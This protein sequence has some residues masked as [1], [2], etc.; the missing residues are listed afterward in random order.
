MSTRLL[1]AGL[2]LASLFLHACGESKKKMPAQTA[3]STATVN[4]AFERNPPI[5]TSIKVKALKETVN[6]NNVLLTATFPRAVIRDNVHSIV[7]NDETLTLRDDGSEGDEKADDGIFSVAINEDLS[8]L[9]EDLIA[10]QNANVDKLN[11][12]EHLFRWSGRSATVIDNQVRESNVRNL[13]FDKGAD[14]NPDLFKLIPDP[15]LRER[16]LMITD[17]GVI[18]DPTRTFNPCTKKGNPKGVWTFSYLISQMANTPASGISVNTF[19]QSWLEKWMAAQ[20]INADNV[21]ARTNI[22]NIVILPWLQASNPGA[23]INTGNWKTFNFDLS[24]APFRLLAIVNRLDLRGNSG[25]KISNAGEGRFVFCVLTPNCTLLR[26]TTI[27]EYGIPKSTCK[28]LHEFAQQWWDLKALVPG[29]AAYND[30][31]QK[32]TDQFTAAG[33]SPSKPNGSSL[34]QLRTNEIALARPWELREFMINK[35][36]IF[37]EVTV[38]QEPALK[39][40]RLSGATAADQQILAKY[41]NDSTAAI[42]AQTYQVPEIEAA[43]G[44]NFLGGKSQMPAPV[45]FWDASNVAGSGFITND[46]VRHILSI[47]TCSGCHAGEARTSVGNLINDP[48]GVPHASFLQIAPQPFGTKPTLSAF[49]TGD[50]SQVDGLFRVTDPAGRPTGSPIQWTFN[51]LARRAEDLQLLLKTE[52]GKSRLV[53]IVRALSFRPL[54]FTH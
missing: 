27:L 33:T 13:D 34:N 28:E 43:S 46:T 2:I 53:G 39:F 5:A 31:L 54:N 12:K 7:V 37:D 47:N 18:E 44:V 40:N 25:Y 50:P 52:C 24:L 19:L 42:L 11:K 10:I 36:G 23:I 30:A 15:E 41:A 48:A 14:I 8:A 29:T 3:A 16:S 32:I 21:P 1:P 20:T 49:L 4:T 17:L 51:D 35:K 45:H 26:F 6:G 22:F 38:K 9:K